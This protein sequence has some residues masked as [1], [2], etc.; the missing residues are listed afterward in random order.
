MSAWRF[1]PYGT[2]RDRS[3]ERANAEA[4]PSTLPPPSIPYLALPTAYPS[5]GTS[6]AR[7]NAEINNP[8][9][10]ENTAPV[11]SFYCSHIPHVTE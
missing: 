6:E 7:A 10:E 9:T 4:G 3:N 8:V 2:P 1:Q 5:G 11:S